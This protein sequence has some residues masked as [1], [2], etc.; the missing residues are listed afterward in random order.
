MIIELVMAIAVVVAMV[1]IADMENQSPFIWGAVAIGMLLLCFMLPI[2]YLRV[3]IAGLLS[4]VAMF[5][6]KVVAN[7]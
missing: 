5:V 7:R 3:V 2:P 6:Y 4:Y 1:K